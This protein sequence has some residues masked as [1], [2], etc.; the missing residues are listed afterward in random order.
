MQPAFSGDDR[1]NQLLASTAVRLPETDGEKTLTDLIITVQLC[2]VSPFVYG[3]GDS[4]AV[5]ASC[6]PEASLDT[7]LRV[8]ESLAG[9]EHRKI[10]LI[11]MD[12]LQRIPDR[13][14]N[15]QRNLVVQTMVCAVTIE[16]QRRYGIHEYRQIEPRQPAHLLPVVS[17]IEQPVFGLIVPW[18][19]PS[20]GT[21]MTS[22]TRGSRPSSYWRSYSDTS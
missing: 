14:G 4:K 22:R 9:L 3:I 6:M 16:P 5:P 17:G 15:V 13:T 19:R 8:A 12:Q 20:T 1:S 10:K 21:S 7:P 11:G 18:S 2:E